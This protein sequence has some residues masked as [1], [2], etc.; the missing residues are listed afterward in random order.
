[1]RV[2]L[3]WELGGNLGHLAGLSQVADALHQRGHQVF[4]SVMDVRDVHKVIDPTHVTLL[5]SPRPPGAPT[6]KD[7]RTWADLIL[8]FGFSDPEV[9]TT[10]LRTWRNLLDLVAPDA[11]VMDSSPLAL[12]ASRGA[13]FPRLIFDN[14]WSLPPRVRPLA[15]VRPGVTLHERLQSEAPVLACIQHACRALDL[16]VPEALEELFE[17]DHA[18]ARSF[19]RLDHYEREDSLQNVGPA[20]SIRGGLAPVWPQAG[21]GRV[22]AYLRGDYERFDAVVRALLA[23]G[24][25][26][27]LYAT[28]VRPEALAAL[29]APNL[30]IVDHPVDFD[31]VTPHCDFAVC[32]S[33]SGTGSAFLVAGVPVLNCPMFLEQ[34]ALGYHASRA[35]LTTFIPPTGP[36][37]LAE[38]IQDVTSPRAIAIA[39]RFQRRHRKWK[40]TDPADAVVR[41]LGA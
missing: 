21:S 11:L 29:R 35:G 16:P 24:R 2:L 32:H 34:Q 5:P 41:A 23:T 8:P 7:P 36:V 15:A 33:L 17:V 37:D 18:I 39:R 28:R 38:R 10:L 4:L 25:Q 14:P 31:L 1:M 30:S 20:F 40:P 19:E 26:V 9:L 22:F 3:T 13:T 12:V 6:V 27:L